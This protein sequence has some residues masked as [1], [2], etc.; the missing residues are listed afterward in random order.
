MASK[1]GMWFV[2]TAGLTDR[3]EAQEFLDDP[4]NPPEGAVID[5][6]LQ[7]LL[8]GLREKLLAFLHN[9]EES[10]MNH[11]MNIVVGDE[12]TISREVTASREKK[13]KT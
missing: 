9:S 2:V 6:M 10:H 3:K 1:M 4:H 5:A 12:E 7:G 11:D 13:A 8:D